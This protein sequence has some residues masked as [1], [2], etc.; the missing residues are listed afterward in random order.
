MWGTDYWFKALKC[1]ISLTNIKPFFWHS[2]PKVETLQK[3]SINIWVFSKFVLKS[4]KSLNRMLSVTEYSCKAF[5][6]RNWRKNT[7]PFFWESGANVETL[8][9]FFSYIWLS[10]KFFFA[11]CQKPKS[12]LMSYGILV[13]GLKMPDFVDK[14]KSI[15]LRK[16][17][18]YFNFLK[19]FFLYLSSL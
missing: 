10:H 11:V 13:Q 5:K 16:R 7:K 4:V 17:S 15:L 19:S 3:F 9:D 2:E 14:Y 1:Q 6:W 12:N 18:K 8:Q